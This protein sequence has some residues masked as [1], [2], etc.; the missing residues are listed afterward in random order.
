MQPTTIGITKAALKKHLQIHRAKLAYPSSVVY[1]LLLPANSHQLLCRFPP[2]SPECKKVYNLLGCGCE[3]R[4]VGF[5][6]HI[7][8]MNSTT[9][10]R[11]NI[12]KLNKNILHEGNLS[13]HLIISY[14]VE[15]CAKIFNKHTK[16]WKNTYGYTI[17]LEKN[18][19][20]LSDT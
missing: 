20:T 18:M 17:F 14:V 19:V 11:K 6:Q 9:F 2:A 3:P 13:K 12:P 10:W 15:S 8:W 4:V 7:L 16:V 5:I 1:A